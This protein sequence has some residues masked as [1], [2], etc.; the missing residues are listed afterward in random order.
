[1]VGEFTIH[2]NE[3]I[4]IDRFEVKLKNGYNEQ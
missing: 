1:M 4:I 3:Q 2:E